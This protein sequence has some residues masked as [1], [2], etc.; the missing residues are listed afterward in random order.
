MGLLQ[1]YANNGATT[2]ASRAFLHALTLEACERDLAE[3]SIT[4]MAW[5]LTVVDCLTDDLIRKA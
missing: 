2:P 5:A 1:A 3:D 4:S